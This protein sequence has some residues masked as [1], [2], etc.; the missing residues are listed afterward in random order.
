MLYTRQWILS[1]GK[2]Q[3]RWSDWVKKQRDN[4]NVMKYVPFRFCE[5]SLVKFFVDENLAWRT[6]LEGLKH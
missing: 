6:Q 3:P 2:V 5:N 4:M 1:R